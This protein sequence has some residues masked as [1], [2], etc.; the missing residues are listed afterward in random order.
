MLSLQFA[1]GTDHFGDAARME[2]SGI[3]VV[4]VAVIAQ[5]EARDVVAGI[6]EFL[7]ERE[8]VHRVCA[9][10]PA[11]QQHGEAVGRQP[12]RIR[13]RCDQREQAHTVAAIDCDLPRRLA[14]HGCAPLDPRPSQRQARVDRLHVVMSQP[15]GRHEVR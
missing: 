5:I 10:F 12:S 11:V 13:L 9:A 1:H 15:P 4:T 8:Q 6:E 14:Q 2:D 7:S 3:E